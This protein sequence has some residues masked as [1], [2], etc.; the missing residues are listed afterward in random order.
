[1]ADTTFV[2]GSTVII[3]DWCNDVNIA[4]Y[5]AIGAGGVAPVTPA[6]VRTNLGLSAQTGAS[7]IGFI[8]SGAGTAGRTAQDKLREIVSVKDFGAV[9]DGIADDTA[10]I[11]SAL[12]TGNSIYV[13]N[14]TY[15]VSSG[16]TIPADD[17]AIIGYGAT[18][19]W[20]SN[21]TFASRFETFQA[22]SR[23]NV[24]IA[25][26]TIDG[27]K[28][29]QANIP[30][31]PSAVDSYGSAF[32]MNSCS[33][34]TYRDVTVKEL[35]GF[36]IMFYDSDGCTIDTF[37][38]KNCGNKR[39]V[40]YSVADLTISGELY[41]KNNVGDGIY[42]E[43]ASDNVV[44]NVEIGHDA[45]GIQNAASL[46]AG[47]TLISASNNTFDGIRVFN[48]C[49]AIH[50]EPNN[51]A[52]SIKYN[53]FSNISIPAIGGMMTSVVLYETNSGQVIQNEFTNIQCNVSNV[54]IQGSR[55]VSVFSSMVTQNY[56]GGYKA[57]FKSCNFP[58]YVT[59]DN[60]ETSWTQC[61]LKGFQEV[62]P[63]AAQ[64]GVL[65]DQCA[66]GDKIYLDQ[67]AKQVTITNCEI[68]GVG[69]RIGGAST[70]DSR[71]QCIIV[72][73]NYCQCSDASNYFFE[74]IYAP[75]VIRNNRFVYTGNTNSS[76]S[77]IGIYGRSGANDAPFL[78]NSNTFEAT[79]NTMTSALYV[80]S[81]A[82]VSYTTDGQ[83]N[84]YNAFSTGWGIDL[85]KL[86]GAA[87]SKT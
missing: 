34:F 47:I 24:F 79:T 72:E 61:A 57:V 31:T 36:G 38:A 13:P 29:N 37:T 85:A 45:D 48:V 15:I 51:A 64:Y 27:N 46:R 11:Q 63:G 83:N 54:L 5:R 86:T 32:R 1:M 6:D 49:R 69:H 77:W 16:I 84:T 81:Y 2:D 76:Y 30:S 18:I 26:I 52:G 40:S 44:F 19:K 21:R 28:E 70:M 41:S 71:Q 33:N 75:A 78:V 17:V 65:I 20:Q 43:N 74:R 62:A 68:Y 56:L 87:P 73:N 59:L 4:T 58:E 42:M 82:D 39:A 3:D 12:N 10:A 53:R 7:L 25:G 14:G 67:G 60:G 8:Q 50:L 9:G 80:P 35:C 55:A 23:K 66:I 22:T